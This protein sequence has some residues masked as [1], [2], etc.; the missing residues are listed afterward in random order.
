VQLQELEA[1]I[2]KLTDE[3]DIALYKIQDG[4]KMVTEMRLK[5]EVAD[6]T[7]TGL[8]SEKEHLTKELKETRLLYRRY[9][10]KCSSLMKELENVNTEYQELKRNNIGYFEATKNR[11]A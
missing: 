1:R 4:Q 2:T 9:E 7:N 5:T 10:E 11:E 3:L 8:M 6:S